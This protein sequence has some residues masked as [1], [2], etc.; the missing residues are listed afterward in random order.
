MT[1]RAD[2]AMQWVD[3]ALDY[4]EFNESYLRDGERDLI[5]SLQQ[6]RLQNSALPEPDL[7]RLQVICRR[8]INQVDRAVAELDFTAERG[9]EG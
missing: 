6:L 1:D 9:V 3:E 2:G 5:D 4:C 7:A 8:I